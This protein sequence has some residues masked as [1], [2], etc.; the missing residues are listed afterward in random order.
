LQQ[1]AKF[2]CS[3]SPIF[4]EAPADPKSF[5]TTFRR[6]PTTSEERPAFIRYLQSRGVFITY[7]TVAA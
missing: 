3:E 4:R 6:D 2:I 1:L 5:L 7:D